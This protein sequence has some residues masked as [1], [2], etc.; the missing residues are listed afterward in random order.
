MSDEK[1]H[2]FWLRGSGKRIVCLRIRV[3]VH[4]GAGRQRIHH[5]PEQWGSNLSRIPRD[6]IDQRHERCEGKGCNPQSNTSTY[7]ESV[8]GRARDQ[9]L[10]W[11]QF[12]SLGD[13]GNPMRRNNS[14]REYVC[15]RAE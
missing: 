13:D 1:A 3:V 12:F 14:L 15:I 11:A 6:A 2:Q 4:A 5:R 7:I 9:C 8:N 10:N